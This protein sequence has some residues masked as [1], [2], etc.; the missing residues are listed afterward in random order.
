MS[1]SQPLTTRC[2][3]KKQYLWVEGIYTILIKNTN[4]NY[5]EVVR[6]GDQKWEVVEIKIEIICLLE[7]CVHCFLYREV[8]SRTWKNHSHLKCQFP[9]KIEIWLRFFLYKPFKKWLNL[10]PSARGRCKLWGPILE[11]WGIGAFILVHTF[12][13]KDI[14]FLCTP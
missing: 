7:I 9:P 13:R 3:Y 14:L 1:F 11:I 10:L 4:T 6:P 5:Q 12:W 2:P 8:S